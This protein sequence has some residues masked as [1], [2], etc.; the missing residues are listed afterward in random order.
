MKP[1]WMMMW[2]AFAAP[3]HAEDGS[4]KQVS[5]QMATAARAFLESLDEAQS[6][7]ARIAF[8]DE[9]R[10][11]WHYIP[12]QR[13]GLPLKDLDERQLALQ[14]RLLE[15]AMSRKG[16][17][18]LDTIILLEGYLAELENNPQRR[19]AT[20]YYTSIFGEPQADGTWGWRFEGH[21]LSLNFTLKGGDHIAVT[22]SFFA[23]NRAHVKEGRLAGTRPLGAEE[24]LAR[25]LARS[26]QAT[27]KPVVYSDRAPNDI[28]TAADRKA[29]QLEPVGV[30]ASE[31]TAA[32]R[33]GLMKLI[34]E[35][36]NRHRPEL[37]K[38]RLAEITRDFD[39]LRFGWAGG[40]EPGQAYYYRIQGA[41]FLVEVSNIQ[42]DANHIHTVWRDRAG[43]FGRDVLG[44]HHQSHA[45]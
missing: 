31:F 45:H 36:A 32:Q 2:F 18:K 35:Y 41:D 33:E 1:A 26:L 3:L 9:E 8:D 22:P 14:R 19:D 12:K 38:D 15:T 28:L 4:L 40:I 10:E 44:K 30:P 16:L 24:D 7:K 27:G 21:H 42:N 23:A 43:D 11:N 17:V 34:T 20:K 13:R 5:A 39:N 6:A 37:E 29:R 25:A